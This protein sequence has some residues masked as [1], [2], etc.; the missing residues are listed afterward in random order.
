MLPRLIAVLLLVT[1]AMPLLVAQE[2]SA[3]SDD[4]I[5]DN[6]RQRLASDADVRGAALDVTVKEGVVTIKGRVHT[7]KG[8]KKAT[9]LTKKVKGVVN[10]DNQLKLY[11]DK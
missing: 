8:R 1:L 10:V 7:E 3:V 6:V 2:K 5:S 9:E 4:T 11:S